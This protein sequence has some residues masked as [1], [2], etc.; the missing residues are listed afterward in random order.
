MYQTCIIEKALL[1]LNSSMLPTKFAF[2]DTET[3]GLSVTKDRIIE[4]GIVRVEDGNVVDTYQTLINPGFNFPEVITHITGITQ[5]QVEQAPAF[6]EVSRDILQLLEGCIFVAHNARFD[7]GFLKNAFKREEISF[8]AKQFC[9]V[10]FSEQ[11]FPQEKSHNLDSI[12]NRFAISCSKRHRAFDDAQVLWEFYQKIQQCI[13][14]DVFVSTVQKILKNPSLPTH[15]PEKELQDLPE[16]PGVYIFY[17]ADDAPLYVGKSI[18]IKDRVQSHFS[19]DYLSAKEMHIAQQVTHIQTLPTTGE[20]GALLKEAL[21]IKK[22]QPL[23]NRKLR[24]SRKMVLVK[25]KNTPNGYTHLY[26]EDAVNIDPAELEDIVGVFRSKR[27][28]KNFLLDK[29]KTYGLCEKLLELEH[30]KGACFGYRLQTCKGAC[31]QKETA[32]FYNA[33]VIE[34]FTKNSLRRWPFTGAIAIVEQDA[35]S[36]D[37][38]YFLIDKWCLLGS[39]TQETIDTHELQDYSYTFD[40]DTYKILLSFLSKKENWKYVHELPAEKKQTRN[41]VT[42]FS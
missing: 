36:Q 6:R 28:A 25:K 1:L 21:L 40:V 19:N 30:G 29:C 37:R 38:E 14:Q 17:G 18:N 7:Y 10:K 9:T 15:L 16:S 2:I 22:L 27:Q 4:I 32:F 33:R 23:Y 26:I 31:I 39:F 35:I 20:L 8:T 34:A 11:L 41:D 42:Y 13:P 3:T 5:Q 24:A 12:I